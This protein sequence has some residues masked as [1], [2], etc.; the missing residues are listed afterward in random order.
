MMSWPAGGH[1]KDGVWAPHWYASVHRSTG[2]AGPEGP[3]PVLEGPARALAD[4]AM[5]HYD[6]MR[7]KT[8]I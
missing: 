4:E 2:F 6:K 7:R 3:L 8:L 1:A 5:E